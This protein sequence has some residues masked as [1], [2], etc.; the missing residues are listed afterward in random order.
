[1][2]Y[3]F[4]IEDNKAFHLSKKLVKNKWVVEGNKHTQDKIFSYDKT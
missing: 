2:Q 3:V 4:T 1:M